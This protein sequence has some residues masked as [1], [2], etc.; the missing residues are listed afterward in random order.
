MSRPVGKTVI[1][2]ADGQLCI[3]FAVDIAGFTRPGRDDE[4]RLYLHEKLYEVLQRAFDGSGVPWADCFHEDRGDGTL[5]VVPPGAVA[6]AWRGGLG[7]GRGGLGLGGAR[8]GLGLGGG[9][10]V[11]AANPRV[12]GGPGS[13]AWYPGPVRCRIPAG[14]GNRRRSAL[15]RAPAPG[16]RGSSSIDVA[17]PQLRRQRCAIGA[18]CRRAPG[19]RRSGRA[20]P[21][22]RAHGIPGTGQRPS[23]ARLGQPGAGR[24]RQDLRDAP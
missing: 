19:P 13:A 11:G 24:S 20:R 1:P 22:G 10:A 7:V 3:V 12:C 15:P 18:V 8:G 21:A 2:P 5:I 6:R 4:I 14:N 17:S 23:R 9:P 16:G